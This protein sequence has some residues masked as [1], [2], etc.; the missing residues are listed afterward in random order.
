[1]L[2]LFFQISFLLFGNKPENQIAH[3]VETL[4]NLA[5]VDSHGR[6]I[7]RKYFDDEGKDIR[8]LNQMFKRF[9][10]VDAQLKKNTLSGEET[11]EELQ[12]EKDTLLV[13][14]S[15][16]SQFLKLANEREDLRTS[17]LFKTLKD[18]SSTEIELLKDPELNQD[19]EAKTKE[20]QK[21]LK[22]YKAHLRDQAKILPF[23]K[24]NRAQKGFEGLAGIARDKG[25]E[26]IE[27]LVSDP[28]KGSIY[29]PFPNDI[30]FAD[31]TAGGS[32]YRICYRI[33]SNNTIF[34]EKIAH[35]T[36]F[37]DDLAGLRGK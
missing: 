26:K 8:F 15:K 19:F 16:Y 25:L 33:L 32:Y 9:Q 13:L 35:R 18:S 6:K 27:E 7:I 1:M 17:L 4:D 29:K 24:S 14:A 20:L 5:F 3:C 30:R 34:I 37:Y 11:R 10:Y 21:A 2:L 22:G 36:N 12:K 28:S 23:P 31:F